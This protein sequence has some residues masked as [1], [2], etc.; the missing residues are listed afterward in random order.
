MK[1]I[2]GILI[3]IFFAAASYA[4]ADI[5]KVDFNNFTYSAYCAGEDLDKI[6][7]KDGEYSKETPQDGYTDRIYFK[8]LKVAYG[9]LNGDGKDEAAILSVCNT[10]GTGNFTE[11]FVYGIKRGKPSLIGRI[12]GGDRAYGGLYGAEIA[13][14]ILFI[15][16]Y[17]AGD[18]G[19]S[20]CPEL[21]V[22]TQYK[23]KAGKLA[24]FK[25]G[26]PQELY[27][28]ERI[29]FARGTS[30]KTVL[31][32]L[33]AGE[34]KRFV[35]GAAA[36][37]TLSVSLDTPKASVRLIGDDPAAEGTR[38]FTAKLPKTGDH[39]IE[40]QNLDSNALPVTMIVKI[41]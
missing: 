39:A 4:Q 40:L 12:P 36:G 26:K 8:I 23:V 24:V 38:G 6:T 41:N 10:G 13:D 28:K 7:V 3:T 25:T 2:P 32:R 31:V 20:C 11:G 14:G 35:L 29:T 1:L 37:Q 19:A 18:G 5:H 16:N 30:S 22:R 27:P 15:D 9:D 21:T 17:E 34:I 33:P